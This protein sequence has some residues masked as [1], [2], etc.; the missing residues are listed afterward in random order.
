MTDGSNK[1]QVVTDNG[2]KIPLTYNHTTSN[3]DTLWKGQYTIPENTS[4]G[5]HKF[6]VEASADSV[7]TDIP[8]HYD[9]AASNSK[10]T[11]Y[12]AEIS[13]LIKFGQIIGAI[14]FDPTTL[15]V[16]GTTT[17]N[18]H[19]DIRAASELQL[20]HHGRLHR[21]RQHHNW[22]HCRCLHCDCQPGW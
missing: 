5:L 7:I 19:G 1:I 12:V 13:Y 2:D 3:G 17:A 20:N 22:R 6:Q 16:G 4:A 10:N 9:V 11:G 14:S 18:S 21:E 8:V 15:T